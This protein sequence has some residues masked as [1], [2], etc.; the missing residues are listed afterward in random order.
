MPSNRCQN[1]W[2]PDEVFEFLAGMGYASH[3]ISESGRLLS[4][5]TDSTAYHS[6]F[7]ARPQNAAR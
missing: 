5:V 4:P 6:D 3:P 2:E 1:T 7:V